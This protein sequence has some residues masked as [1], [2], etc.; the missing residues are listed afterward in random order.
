MEAVIKRIL[1][2]KST[3]PEEL[4]PIPL[5]LFHKTK[6][7]RTWPNLFYKAIVGYPDT[8]TTQRLNKEG[9][10]QKLQFLLCKPTVPQ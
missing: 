7:E 4:M 10:L 5:K 2:K 8:Q 1:P 9:E 6:P 3:G